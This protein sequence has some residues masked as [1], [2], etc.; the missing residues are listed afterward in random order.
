M[1]ASQSIL[2]SLFNDEQRLSWPQQQQQ[3]QQEDE[4][5][6]EHTHGAEE[7]DRVE[8]YMKKITN[9]K[10][11]DNGNGGKFNGVLRIKQDEEYKELYRQK[12]KEMVAAKKQKT[13][14]NKV[15]KGNDKLRHLE[16]DDRADEMKC[17]FMENRFELNRPYCDYF[18]DPYP[19]ALVKDSWY[20]KFNDPYH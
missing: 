11:K 12:M 19:D 17:S 6:Y 16:R 2:L 1:F 4:S 3:Q 20:D 13:E 8:L 9:I 10:N 15:Y 5:V 14:N 18:L 7:F